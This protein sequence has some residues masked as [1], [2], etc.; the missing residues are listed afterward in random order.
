AA[1]GGSYDDR[2]RPPALDDRRRRRDLRDRPRPDRRARL[3]R[4]P[5]GEARGLRD[6]LRGAVRGRARGGALRGRGR[7]AR[8]GGGG[9]R[10]VRGFGLPRGARDDGKVVPRS[11]ALGFLVLIIGLV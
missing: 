10:A 5:A 9:G 2:D 7:A 3:A 11:V 4:G 8:R 1:D 6:A